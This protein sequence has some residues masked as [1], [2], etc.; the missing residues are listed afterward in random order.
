MSEDRVFLILWEHA[1]FHIYGTVEEFLEHYEHLYSWPGWLIDGDVYWNKDTG[2]F[3]LFSGPNMDF[4]GWVVPWVQL[5]GK[6]H[7][8]MLG[9]L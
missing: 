4:E 3:E 7:Y 2:R 8:K 9:D 1:N 5:S 6:P